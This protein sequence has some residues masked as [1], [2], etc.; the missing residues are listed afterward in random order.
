MRYGSPR[1]DEFHALQRR[2][3]EDARRAG[4]PQAHAL[5]GCDWA[6]RVTAAVVWL[7]L[8]WRHALKLGQGARL[9]TA[10]SSASARS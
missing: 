6:Q 3:T 1:S 9:R 8:A 5:Y 4:I 7:S 2:L 10:V